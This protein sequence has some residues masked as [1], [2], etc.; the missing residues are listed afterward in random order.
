VLGINGA[1]Y[2]GTTGDMATSAIVDE[3]NAFTYKP[4]GLVPIDEQRIVD[5]WYQKTPDQLYVSDDYTR[6]KHEFG[7]HDAE[8]ANALYEKVKKTIETIKSE[9][10]KQ[11]AH[12]K[13]IAQKLELKTTRELE[14]RQKHETDVAQKYNAYIRDVQKNV[15]R[16]QTFYKAQLKRAMLFNSNTALQGASQQTT[17]AVTVGEYMLTFLPC[18][19]ALAPTF[20]VAM[21]KNA[22]A[23]EVDTGINVIIDF[24]NE[25]VGNAIVKIVGLYA[26]SS[27]ETIETLKAYMLKLAAKQGYKQVTMEDGSTLLEPLSLSECGSLHASYFIKATSTLDDYEIQPAL[28]V[29]GKFGEPAASIADVAMRE[30]T[31][32]QLRNN[33]ESFREHIESC[34][35]TMLGL[36]S[37]T[38]TNAL[39]G[40]IIARLTSDYEKIV[41]SSALVLERFEELQSAMD[42]YASSPTPID[43]LFQACNVM[44]TM[45]VQMAFTNIH[46]G[47][48]Y[49][50]VAPNDNVEIFNQRVRALEALYRDQVSKITASLGVGTPVVIAAIQAVLNAGDVLQNEAYT[51]ARVACL[52]NADP[53][54]FE[55]ESLYKLHRRWLQLK[56]ASAATNGVLDVYNYISMIYGTDATPAVQQEVFAEMDGESM[57]MLRTKFQTLN[58]QAKYVRSTILDTQARSLYDKYLD[59]GDKDTRNKAFRK[60]QEYNPAFFEAGGFNPDVEGTF[61][62][63][64]LFLAFLQTLQNKYKA[65]IPMEDVQPSTP[66]NPN[67]RYF[68]KREFIPF[69][70]DMRHEYF[71]LLMN[72]PS[73]TPR[74]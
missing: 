72:V 22:C 41:E 13:G 1:I 36:V 3:P 61:N 73:L 27:V 5:E 42:A 62:M 45:C 32:E 55:I 30:N 54:K 46:I 57:Q 68:L 11:L 56:N 47:T 12:Y 25:T 38:I 24:D 14:E 63:R 29:Q 40:T 34:Q 64:P 2:T 58:E 21:N 70:F 59:D 60:F 33:I 9:H 31:L 43:Q 18:I 44:F 28:E 52:Q 7:F 23:L 51:S 69:D 39:T 17:T 67:V 74:A 53:R 6:I 4:H 66:L 50:I 37:T 10:T 15:D 49:R 71:E 19:P 26:T 35:K 8:E 16:F 65:R 20:R 48:Q